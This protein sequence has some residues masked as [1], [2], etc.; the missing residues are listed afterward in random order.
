MKRSVHSIPTAKSRLSELIEAAL[1]GEEVVI[2]R[3]N[4]P[5]VR[6]VPLP[7]SGFRLGVMKGKLNTSPDFHEPMS[8]DE[9]RAWEGR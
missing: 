1:R 8:E 6:L 5:V 9:L 4:R 2:A 3:G 7:Q